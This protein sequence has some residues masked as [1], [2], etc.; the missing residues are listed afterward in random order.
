MMMDV[1]F[2]MG[3]IISAKKYEE[4]VEYLETMAIDENARETFDD[5]FV[6]HLA[7]DTYF[8]GAYCGILSYD[9]DFLVEPENEFEDELREFREFMNDFNLFQF[10]SEWR[11]DVHVM[12]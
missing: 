6:F 10:C 5:E 8:I 4:I 7:D 11:P 1:F 3:T 12:R 2:G 9:V